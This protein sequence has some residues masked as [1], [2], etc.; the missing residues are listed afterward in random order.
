MLKKQQVG[1]VG[2][3]EGGILRWFM[4]LIEFFKFANPVIR[5]VEKVTLLVNV[6]LKSV[7]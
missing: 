1:E 5:G 3:G 6:I 7:A 2:V 4:S